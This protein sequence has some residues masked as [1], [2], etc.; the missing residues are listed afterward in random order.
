[1]ITKKKRHTAFSVLV[2]HYGVDILAQVVVHAR[3][4]KGESLPRHVGSEEEVRGRES[5]TFR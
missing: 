1:M 4:R 5:D 2:Y 3:S